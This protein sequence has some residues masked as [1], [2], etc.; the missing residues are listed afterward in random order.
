MPGKRLTQRKGVRRKADLRRHGP[1]GNDDSTTVQSTAE[2]DQSAD[3]VTGKKYLANCT[4]II[5]SHLI[6]SVADLVMSL[7]IWLLLRVGVLVPATPLKVV[8]PYSYCAAH[9]MDPLTSER[10]SL[11]Y[12]LVSVAN[13]RHTR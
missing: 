1:A 3:H 11:S 5:M 9:V 6:A 4:V 8:S 13:R 12:E 7:Q 2:D 10:S